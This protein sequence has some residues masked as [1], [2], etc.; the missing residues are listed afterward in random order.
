MQVFNEAG[1][2]S[3]FESALKSLNKVAIDKIEFIV[4]YSK[5]KSVLDYKQVVDFDQRY[6]GSYSTGTTR[7]DTYE[8]YS[9]IKDVTE[10]KDKSIAVEYAFIIDKTVAS[11]IYYKNISDLLDRIPIVTNDTRDGKYQQLK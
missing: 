6:T 11:S 4:L 1:V 2:F 8:V 3:L 10:V 9:V 7:T 5:S